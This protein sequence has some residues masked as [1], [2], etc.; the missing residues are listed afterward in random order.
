MGYGGWIHNGRMH[1]RTTC[2]VKHGACAVHAMPFLLGAYRS[3]RLCFSLDFSVAFGLCNS[4]TMS[5]RDQE[6]TEE[7]PTFTEAQQRWIERL[8][9][10]KILEAAPATTTSDTTCT[11]S[12]GTPVVTTSPATTAGHGGVGEYSVKMGG[13][14]KGDKHNNYNDGAGNGRIQVNLCLTSSATAGRSLNEQ[15]ENQKE[16]GEACHPR[17]YGGKCTEQACL[18]G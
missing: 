7:P 2:G 11:V 13:G 15:L 9:A 17:V 10:N 14:V 16:K 6:G 4:R 5:T 12:S 8:I 3:R 18:C 1:M